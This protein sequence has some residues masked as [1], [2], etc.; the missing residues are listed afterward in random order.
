MG[1]GAVKTIAAQLRGQSVPPEV[2]LKPLLIT[3][4]NLASPQVRQALYM[5][6]WRP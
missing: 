2:R 3:R 4:E 5:E 6:W 1:L